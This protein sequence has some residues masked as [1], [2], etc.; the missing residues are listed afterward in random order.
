MCV[1]FDFLAWFC[2]C[3]TRAHTPWHVCTHALH[4]LPAWHTLHSLPG[5]HPLTLH[6]LFLLQQFFE[7]DPEWT[8]DLFFRSNSWKRFWTNFVFTIKEVPIKELTSWS[9]STRNLLKIRAPNKCYVLYII[10]LTPPRHRPSKNI[11]WWKKESWDN[12]QEANFVSEPWR[13]PCLWLFLP[14]NYQTCSCIRSKGILATEK[15]MLCCLV[16]R[17]ISLPLYMELFCCK[18]LPS[19]MM[20]FS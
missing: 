20:L 8:C 7:K 19:N 4:T 16:T 15:L 10:L 14:I 13:I 9:L 17:R 12:K 11:G 1:F 6:P 3:S 2:G 5:G 18:D